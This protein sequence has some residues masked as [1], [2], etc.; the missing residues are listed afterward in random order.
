LT[1]QGIEA[2]G[3][4]PK[5]R[6][7]L[8]EQI[9]R[10]RRFATAM[11]TDADRAG[12]EKMAADYERELAD[13]TEAPQ[14]QPSAAPDRTGGRGPIKWNYGNAIR[15]CRPECPRDGNEDGKRSGADGLARWPQGVAVT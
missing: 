5:S 13:A 10:A 1:G 6:Q 15:N 8:L 3:V 11:N 9:A 2:D 14:R 7:F 4:M 12:F